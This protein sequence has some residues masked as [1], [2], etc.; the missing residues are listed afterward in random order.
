MVR[1]VQNLGGIATG[2]GLDDRGFGFQIPIRVKN[3]L[4]VVQ[5]GSGAHQ[6]SYLMG[7]EGFF[8]GVKRP[9]RET[10]HS[11]PT[12]AEVRKM[13]IYT[14]A[15]PY[16]HRDFIFL[17]LRLSVGSVNSMERSPSWEPNSRSPGQEILLLF[18]GTKMVFTVI[19]Q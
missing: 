14:S 19:M 4:N 8:P 12:S 2:Y 9:E 5:A 10:D 15:P 18:S 3:F 16:V 6:A 17:P 7:T 1:E 13:W 11:P